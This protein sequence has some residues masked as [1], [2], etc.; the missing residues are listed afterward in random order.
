MSK[1]TLKFKTETKQLLDLMIHSIYTN[2]DIILRELLSN[3][4]D[5]IDKIKFEAL[6]D[7][8][9]VKDDEDFEIYIDVDKKENTISVSDNGIGMTYEDLKDNIGTIARSGTKKFMEMIEEAKKS[10]SEDTSDLIGQFGVGFYSSFMISEKVQIETK[11]PHDDKGYRWISDGEGSYTIEEIEKENRGT[12]VT[13]FLKDEYCDQTDQENNYAD[14]HKLEELVKKY[15]DFIRY[16]IKMEFVTQEMP[17]DKDGKPIEGAKPELKSEVRI[18]NSMKPIWVKTKSEVKDEEYN[19]FYKH[20]FHDWEEP[21]SII[22][23]KAEGMIQYNALLFLPGRAPFDYYTQDYKGGIKLYSKNVFIMD[24][25]DKLLPEYMKF[26][27]GIVD[28]PDFSLNISREILQNNRQLAIIGKNLEKKVLNELK[29]MLDKDFE[30]YSEFWK[31]FGRSIKAGIYSS[32]DNKEKLQ[33]LLLFQTLNSEGKE[34]TLKQYVENMPEDQKEIYFVSG[35]DVKIVKNLPQLES[36]KEKGYDVLFFVDPVDEFMVNNLQEFDGKKIK[37]IQK[38]DIDLGED[39]SN[40]EEEKKKE[41]ESKDLIAAIQEMLQGKV[42]EVKLSHRLKSSPVCLVT[43][44]NGMSLNMESMM[45]EL[46][47]FMPKAKKI[48]EINPNHEV[49]KNLETKFKNDSKSEDIKIYSEML[50]AQAQLIEGLPLENPAEFA[51][52]LSKLMSSK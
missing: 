11:S 5:A 26:V 27:K 42:D 36:V 9:L 35:S 19:E 2:H 25:C 48:L 14:E 17:K 4:S 44:D 37:S 33:D 47:Q 38:G 23:T 18:V 15:S 51:N 50:L 8:S 31:E 28:S 32:P 20:T 40:K 24:N 3:S 12:K 52:N 13:L 34:I 41:E 49:Y 1:K 10:D 21:K 43:G 29:K 39:D 6:T 22:Q 16:P 46:N 7:S 30:K 45:K